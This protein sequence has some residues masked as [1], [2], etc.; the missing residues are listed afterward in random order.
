MSQ[1]LKDHWLLRPDVDYLNHGSFGATPRCVLAAQ[2]EWI[3]RLE[4]EP[5]EFLAP[6]RTLLPKLDQVRNRIAKLVHAAAPDIAFVRNATDGVN[7]VVRSLPLQA[8][9]ELLVT[10]H[11]Y[12][13]CTNA[14]RYAAERCGATVVT[15][16][17]PF[18]IT[19]SSEVIDSIAACLTPRT[20]WILIDHVT[21]PTGIILPVDEIVQL[22]H[23]RDIRIMIDGAHAPG[24]LPLNLRQTQPDFYTA[25]HHKWLCGPKASGFL[26]VRDAWQDEVQPTVISHGANSDGYGESRFQSNFNWPG[27]FDPAPILALPTALDFLAGLH[28]PTRGDDL[29]TLMRS[30]HELVVAGRRVILDRLQ[31]DEPAPESMLG[32]IATIPIPAWK[33][34]TGEEI[35]A[36]GQLLRSEHRFEL[37]IFQLNEHLGCLRISAQAYNSLEQYER[38][39]SVLGD[40]R[41]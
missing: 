22:A 32:S 37:P 28:P 4:T 18:P 6:E 35:N 19:D 16:N 10:N 2:Q 8:G 3:T 24:M 29:T 11:G 25:N 12:K 27:T 15:A 7:A 1:S 17:L 21:S 33:Q 23:S 38:L 26:Y 14:V 13:A 31:I 34:R 40:V 20:R 5:I 36:I 39:A 9:D 30:N 41:R